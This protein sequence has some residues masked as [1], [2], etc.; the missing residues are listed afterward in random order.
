MKTLLL[1]VLLSTNTSACV[2]V[3]DF[4]NFADDPWELRA[5]EEEVEPI[6]VLASFNA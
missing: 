5:A 2:S 1:L 3:W 4:L 6:P